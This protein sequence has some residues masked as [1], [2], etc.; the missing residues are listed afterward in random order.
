MDKAELFKLTTDYATMKSDATG[1][2]YVTFPG[3]VVIPGSGV[4]Y[5]E[6]FLSIGRK[7][8]LI[9]SRIGSSKDGN[10]MYTASSLT[11]ARTG[12]SAGNVA[13]Y[14]IAAYCSRIDSVTMRFVAIVKNPTSVQLTTAAGN[15]VFTFNVSTFIPP[16]R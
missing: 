13:F 8:A 3:S 10:T 4:R 12:V 6:T 14:N 7:G 11:M 15:E 2:A 1:A 9:R 16:F 5:F